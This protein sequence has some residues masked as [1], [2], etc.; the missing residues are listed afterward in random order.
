MIYAWFIFV[1]ASGTYAGRELYRS[2]QEYFRRIESATSLEECDLA[3]ER[4]SAN[5][6]FWIATWA[7]SSF[8]SGF[9]LMLIDTGVL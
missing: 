5:G 4:R 1:I 8:L 6:S 9:V 3:D 2:E 7:L